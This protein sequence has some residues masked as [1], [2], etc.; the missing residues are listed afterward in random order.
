MRMGD[1]PGEMMSRASGRKLARLEELPSD[2]LEMARSV[3]PWLIKDPIE[4]L[5]AKVGQITVAV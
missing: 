2:Y 3:H 1:H 5:S 4:T